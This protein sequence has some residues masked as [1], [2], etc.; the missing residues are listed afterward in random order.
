MEVFG[1]ENLIMMGQ[2]LLAAFLGV[3]VGAERELARKPAGMRTYALV[4]MGACIFTII[5]IFAGRMSGMILGTPDDAFTDVSRI[6]AQVVVGIGFIG[7]GMAI[8]QGTKVR[9]LTTAAGVWVSAAIG[10]AIGFRMYSIAI[11]TT[12]V[13]LLIF[14]FLWQLE[15][16]IVKRYAS[17]PPEDV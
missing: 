9:G 12:L 15:V 13:V 8:F 7:A 3:L 5:S 4:S 10:M 6:A 14:V 17:E 2:I 16:R 11:F 1:D